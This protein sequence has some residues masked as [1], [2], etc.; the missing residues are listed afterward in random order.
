MRLATWNLREF[1]STSYGYRSWEAKSYIAEILSHFDLIALQEIRR[2][3]SAL[4]DL[5]RLLGPAWDYIATDVTEGAS[6]NHE[7]M[8]FLFNRNRVGFLGV[9][10]ELTLPRGSKI[11]DPFGERFRVKGGPRLAFP[12][13]EMISSKTGLK[14]EK[15]KLGNTKLK[16]DVEIELPIDTRLT[17]PA[18]SLVRFSKNARVPLNEKGGIAIDATST[19]TL[20]DAAEIVLPQDSVVSGSMQFARTPFI[21]SFRA[22][23]LHLNLATVHIYFGKGQSG[24]KRRQEEIQRL[25]KLLAKRAKSDHDSESEAHFIAL[26]D[27]NIVDRDH[28]T[29]EA[30]VSNGFEIPDPLQSIPGSNVKQ[31][32][33]Y[34]QIAIW[35]GKSKR[36]KGYTHIRARGAGV[37]DFFDVVYRREDQETYGP[38]MRKPNSENSYASYATWRTHQMSDHLPMWVE[39]HTDFAAEYIA[40]T[41]KDIKKALAQTSGSTAYRPKKGRS[42]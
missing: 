19:P 15:L 21:A 27:F 5:R 37:F 22:G 25:T 10:G 4:D 1:D 23:W 20:A 11:A 39:L 31:D 40:E 38:L 3:L 26:G 13:G 41:E 42:T 32:K 36:R 2:D 35:T 12:E 30:L 14:T 33:F 29:M 8:A 16:E 28:A 9:A 17:L 34:D 24:L 18:G 6:G 7:R